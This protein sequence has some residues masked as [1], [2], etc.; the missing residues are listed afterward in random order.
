[1]GKM[2]AILKLA[3]DPLCLR[4]KMWQILFCFSGIYSIT[5]PNFTDFSKKKKKKKNTTTHIMT[6]LPRLPGLDYMF[7]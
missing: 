4:K 7:N 2:A 6:K 5:Y 1:M 3:S